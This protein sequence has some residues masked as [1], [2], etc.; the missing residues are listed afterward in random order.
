MRFTTRIL[1]L[2]FHSLK[3]STYLLSKGLLWLYVKKKK[4]HDCLQLWNFSSR[5]Q[6]DTKKLLQFI[7]S[8]SIPHSFADLTHE[9]ASYTL[10]EK[11]HINT[12]FSIIVIQ[13]NAKSLKSYPVQ[14][15]LMRVCGLIAQWSVF[16]RSFF[17]HS[18]LN[19]RGRK[20]NLRKLCKP[21]TQ[22]RVCITFEKFPNLPSV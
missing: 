19:T 5:V 21:D 1:K 18:H 20:E 7:F 17:T 12:H 16:L 2:I 22:S 4:I 10:E 14:R 6:L 15:V 3:K 8:C 13:P 9:I 11:F